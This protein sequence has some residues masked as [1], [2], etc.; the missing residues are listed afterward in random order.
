MAEVRFASLRRCF[1]GCE[2]QKQPVFLQRWPSPV[3]VWEA[4]YKLGRGFRCGGERDLVL[5]RRARLAAPVLLTAHH[6]PVLV[7]TLQSDAKPAAAPLLLP[8]PLR[9]WCHAVPVPLPLREPPP[10]GSEHHLALCRG[11]AAGSRGA[12]VTLTPFLSPSPGRKAAS[13]GL[14]TAC[15]LSRSRRREGKP[16]MPRPSCPRSGPGL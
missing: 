12:S 3:G 9:G 8:H 15:R 14:P 5:T 7:L 13:L 10:L 4:A 1:P 2:K 6:G 16:S 11:P